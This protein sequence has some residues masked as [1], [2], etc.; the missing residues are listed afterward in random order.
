MQL[1]LLETVGLGWPTLDEYVERIQAVTAEQVRQVANKYLSEERLT[2]AILD[3][4]PLDAK[5]AKLQGAQYH[6]R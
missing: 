3:P 4:L 2:V 6:G 5:T 1:G